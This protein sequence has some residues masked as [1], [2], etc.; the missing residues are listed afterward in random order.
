MEQVFKKHS[1]DE[2]SPRTDI[3]HT[4]FLNHEFT[5]ILHDRFK[6]ETN[7]EQG[8]D[9]YSTHDI[10]LK[11]E[12]PD[13]YE[14]IKTRFEQLFSEIDK[15]WSLKRGLE[16]ERIFVVKYSEGTQLQLKEHVDDSYISGS[17]KLNTD[18]EGGVL[19]FP[20]QEITN[21]DIGIGD[22]IIWPSQITHTHQSTKVTKGEKYSITIW[23]DVKKIS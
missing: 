11:I 12:Y 18:Y 22:L 5:T 1:I 21:K 19:H 14:I 20:R 7:W 9:Q 3:L 23:T 13:L 2:L 17:I 4:E 8:T 16:V 15:I 10:Q 6:E